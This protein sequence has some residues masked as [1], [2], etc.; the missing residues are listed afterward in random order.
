[1][2]SELGFKDPSYFSRFFKRGTGR[3]PTQ[4]RAGHSSSLI[5]S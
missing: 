1:M 3:T 2:S 5:G 4:F